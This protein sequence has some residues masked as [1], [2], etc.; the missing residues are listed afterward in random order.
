MSALVESRKMNAYKDLI[1]VDKGDNLT[2]AF[3][4]ADHEWFEDAALIE[5]YRHLVISAPMMYALLEKVATT[6]HRT[7][8]SI[9]V[10][11]KVYE[12]DQEKALMQNIITIFA[13]LK[14]DALLTMRA[15]EVG[16][17][18]AMGDEISSRE[19]S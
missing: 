8:A 5:R 13:M 7:I 12:S 16:P 14:A 4:G 15:A 10:L 11:S 17:L 18:K 19:N 1:F 9:E 2:L 3:K 6:A